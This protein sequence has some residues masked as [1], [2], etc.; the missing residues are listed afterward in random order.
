M[1]HLGSLSHILVD[2]V[3]RM[4]LPLLQ[5]RIPYTLHFEKIVVFALNQP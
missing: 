5:R 1:L 4:G 3:T 2:F